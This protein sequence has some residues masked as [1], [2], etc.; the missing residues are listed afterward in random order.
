MERFKD[1]NKWLGSFGDI[2]HVKCPKCS[3]QAIV[4][5]TFDSDFYYRDKRVLECKHCYYSQKENKVK[6]IAYVDTYCCNNEDKIKFQSQLLNDKPEKIKLKCI[7]CNQIKEFKPKILE[8]PFVANTDN[9]VCTEMWFNA[10][11]WYQTGIGRNVF[12][13]FNL[14]HLIY[15][16][17]Y[18]KA[19]LRER[20]ALVTYS[21][22][23]VAKLPK[24]I[25]E[26]KNREK[27][28]K[29]IEK[30]KK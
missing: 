4:R 17:K 7:V 8:I 9:K 10:E 16:E 25:K 27:L 30:W 21:S 2:I 14:E 5:R 22:T 12:L 28:L 29:I 6:Y 11:L 19:D 20:N 15:M 18:I 1:E 3:L 23:L 26:A 13:A 24:F